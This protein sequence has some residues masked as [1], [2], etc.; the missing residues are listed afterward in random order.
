MKVNKIFGPGVVAISVIIG[1]TGCGS[2]STDTTEE[3]S[4]TPTNSA[5]L[6]DAG[7]AQTISIGSTVTLS[8]SASSDP[9]GDSLAYNWVFDSIPQDSAAVLQ[10][11]TTVSPS[12][13]A[14]IAGI[15]IASLIVN[16]GTVD[17]VADTVNIVVGTDNV[18][19]TDILFSNRDGACESYAGR[20]FSNVSDIQRG[21]DYSGDV[22]VSS[23]GSNCTVSS[24]EIP[25]HDFNDDTAAFA[26]VVSEQ[27]GSYSV[28]TNPRMQTVVTALNLNTT[29][30]VF[31]N[32][33]T[34]DLLAAACYD[35]GNEPVG[36][37]KIGCGPDQ[38]DNPWR[39]DPMSDANGFGTDIH[40]AHVQPDGTYHYH[41]NPVA[42][43][44]Q[45]CETNAVASPVIGF[46]ADG[47]PVFGSC[48]FEQGTGSVKKAQ[49]SY[50]LKD[51]GG[52]RQEVSPYTTPV[53]GVGAVV[54]S[55]YDGQFTGDWEYQEGVGDLD[56]CNGMTVDGQYGYYITDSYPWVLGCY[57]GTVNDSFVKQGP[58]LENRLHSHDE[59]ELHSH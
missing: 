32:G 42:M 4:V 33:T 19:I 18:D 29:N 6:A 14:D 16:D 53:G 45:D 49:S 57:K 26:S 20:Y 24:N 2:S 15:Y 35:V 40:N 59:G 31:L 41:G 21:L 34:L 7:E 23:D 50:A 38:I 27:S 1:L 36:E 17:S 55:N 58:G 52:P 10:D 12:F 13:V 25:N 47:Y 3:S 48:F 8:A 51:D 5:P 44:D 54:S 39:Y 30:A 46:A 22:V 9:D 56:E 11:Q 43:F 37:E 28:S